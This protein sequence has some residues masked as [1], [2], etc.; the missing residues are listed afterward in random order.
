MVSATTEGDKTLK[1]FWLVSFLYDKQTKTS[2]KN[3]NV[4]VYEQWGV[5]QVSPHQASFA[6]DSVT[7]AASQAQHILHLSLQLPLLIFTTVGQASKNKQNEVLAA[8]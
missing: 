8:K 1:V 6:G 4:C 5:I 7:S 2:R 3:Q